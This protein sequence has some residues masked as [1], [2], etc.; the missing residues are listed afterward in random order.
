M[1]PGLQ[2]VQ[3]SYRDETQDELPRRLTIHI[4][5][6]EV[7]QELL[8]AILRETMSTLIHDLSHL[9]P[10]LLN[11]SLQMLEHAMRKCLLLLHLL[12][13]VVFAE[14]HAPRGPLH[15]SLPF[16]V[17]SVSVG[18]LLFHSTK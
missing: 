12:Q 3:C 13:T 1:M 15:I 11:M 4:D 5:L 7:N 2:G 6:N 8:V 14:E 17:Y 18:M 10:I 16:E 9:P